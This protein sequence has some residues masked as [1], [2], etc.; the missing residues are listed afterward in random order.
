MGKRAASASSGV[1]KEN[2]SANRGGTTSSLSA[3]IGLNTAMTSGEAQVCVP[4]CLYPR[5]L[6]PSP[7]QRGHGYGVFIADAHRRGGLGYSDT[8][9]KGRTARMEGG[10]TWPRSHVPPPPELY[11]GDLMRDF[12]DVFE[13]VGAVNPE[14]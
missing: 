7:F 2:Q 3:N 10:G 4:H 6:F 5:K 1:D 12:L 9:E 13:E 8:P 14:P 11:G